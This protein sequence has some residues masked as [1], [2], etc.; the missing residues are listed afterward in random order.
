V[1]RRLFSRRPMPLHDQSGALPCDGCDP[2]GVRPFGLLPRPRPVV[3]PSDV[4][5]RVPGRLETVI[6][7]QLLV[8]DPAGGR[9]HLLNTSAALVYTS[10]DG[11]ATVG[12]IVDDLMADLGGDR[13]TFDHDVPE[14]VASLLES[15]LVTLFFDPD[16]PDGAAHPPVPPDPA[17]RWAAVVSRRLADTAWPL[18]LGPF[19][20]AGAEVSARMDDERVAEGLAR[21]LGSLPAAPATNGSPRPTDTAVV[22]I[23][24]RP[25]G[26]GRR[27]RVHADGARI[28]WTDDPD[29]A[30]RYALGAVNQLAALHT[31]DRLVLHAGA[32]ER[33]GRVVALTGISGQGKTTL[34]AALVQAGFGYVTDELVAIDPSTRFVDPF[35]KALDLDDHAVALLGLDPPAGPSWPSTESSDAAVAPTHEHA[36]DPASLGRISTGGRLAAVVVLT[37]PVA[38][39]VETLAPAQALTELLRGLFPAT[40]QVPGA[41]EA[42]AGV[43][44]DVPVVRLPRLALDRAVAAVETLA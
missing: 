34:T 44:Q 16:H 24:S 41:L 12:G 3:T 20:A 38:D 33:D 9:S 18:R 22:S 31:P 5:A 32:V 40:W 19:R 37:G 10:V 15:G 43:C 29:R 42:L 17:D 14:T 6:D 13:A 26:A 2:E 11:R 1:R 36:I 4:V 39:E 7:G 8:F 30:V 35:P 23:D 27:Y 28:G 25:V 21:A